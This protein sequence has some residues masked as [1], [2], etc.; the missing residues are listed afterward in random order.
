M[1]MPD[2][3]KRLSVLFVALI[4]AIFVSALFAHSASAQSSPDGAFQ[5]VDTVTL[6]D[7]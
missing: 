7:G 5:I 1:S 4:M 2:N 6:T 3:T